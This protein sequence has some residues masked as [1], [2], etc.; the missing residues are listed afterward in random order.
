MNYVFDSLYFRLKN[1]AIST[2]QISV[3]HFT[4]LKQVK[5]TSGFESTNRVSF[6][7]GHHPQN[8]KSLSK[9]D[10][11]PYEQ[12]NGHRELHH[13]P[14]FPPHP[15]KDDLQICLK[16]DSKKSLKKLL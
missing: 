11:Y 15:Q 7:P 13:L 12:T 3:N 5:F 1:H 2:V 6:Q 4:L 9:A 8:V 14:G 16:L 10:L